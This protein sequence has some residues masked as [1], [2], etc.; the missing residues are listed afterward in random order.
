MPSVAV[1]MSAIRDLSIV[2]CMMFA[3]AFLS[4]ARLP[5]QT[6]TG[7]VHAAGTPVVGATV[8][9]LELDRIEHSGA[10]GQFTFSNI[11][12]GIYRV[13]VGVTGYASATNT[14][15]VMN[16]TTKVSFDLRES[17]IQL[18]EIVVSASPNTGI[19]VIVGA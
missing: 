9:L 11:P 8:R 4:P 10:R 13:F 18:K 19:F 12:R 16:D 3:A 14:V 17:A 6:V 15:E 7:T 5:A 1:C 2:T